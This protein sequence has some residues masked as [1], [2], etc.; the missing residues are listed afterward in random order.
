MVTNKLYASYI[1]VDYLILII[2]I[3]IRRKIGI[4]IPSLFT[5]LFSTLAPMKISGTTRI[6]LLL[7]ILILNIAA[8]QVTKSMMRA[9]I[10][11]YDQ[12]PFFDGHVTLLHVENTGAF[13]SIGG[14]LVQPFRFILLTLVPIFALAAA[15][16]YVLIKNRLSMLLSV[17]IIFC[18]GGGMG[19]LYDRIVHGSVTDF[20][21]LKFGPLQTGIF[22]AADVS[23]MAGLGLILLDGFLRRSDNKRNQ[24]D[25]VRVRD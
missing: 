21:H 2:S 17:G 5:I 24:T 9:H 23:I 25:S 22:N 18:I 7:V 4:A 1:R 11:F 14:K 6:I 19:N 10:G 3:E 13:L 8:D 12:Y 16:A 15:M 20:M